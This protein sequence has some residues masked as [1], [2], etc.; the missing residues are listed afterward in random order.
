MKRLLTM[1]GGPELG[2]LRSRLEAAGIG[3][4]LRDEQM[5]QTIHC[6]AF[7]AELWILDDNDYSKAVGLCEAWKGPPAGTTRSWICRECGETVD[8]QFVACWRC[9]TGREGPT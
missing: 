5:S 1:P 6:A 3:C 8:G 7:P 4:E 2:L 9:G